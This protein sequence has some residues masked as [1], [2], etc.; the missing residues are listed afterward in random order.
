M[1]N[2]LVLGWRKYNHTFNHLRGLLPTE[3]VFWISAAGLLPKGVEGVAAFST[4]QL[5]AVKDDKRLASASC[6]VIDSLTTLQGVYLSASANG[7]NPE[8][9]DYA[10]ASYGVLDF[11]LGMAEK[12]IPMHALLDL[13]EKVENKVTTTEIFLS[14]MTEAFAYPF[15]PE[16][17]YVFA[18]TVDGE[19]KVMV[20]DDT[21]RALRLVQKGSK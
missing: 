16:V 20:Q 13:R 1:E 19:Q 5:K 15:F 12:G 7:K 6:L 11:L 4:K 3:G 14:P 17:R 21:D 10:N 18:K 2:T 8:Q 9:R